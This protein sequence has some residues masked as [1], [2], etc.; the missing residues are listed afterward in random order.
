V[1]HVITSL[2]LGN[3]ITAKQIANDFSDDDTDLFGDIAD[4][5]HALQYYF[6]D[7]IIYP[8]IVNKYATWRVVKAESDKL[9]GYEPMAFHR[10][11]AIVEQAKSIS[12]KR[13]DLIILTDTRPA[14]WT[15]FSVTTYESAGLAVFLA[16]Y[17]ALTN[18]KAKRVAATG[19]IERTL[20]P[21]QI[22]GV[23]KVGAV[24]QKLGMLIREAGFLD[25]E[26]ILYPMANQGQV[27]KKIMRAARDKGIELLAV[28]DIADALDA[29]FPGHS[30]IHGISLNDKVRALEA[31]RFVTPYDPEYQD[32]VLKTGYALLD[33]LSKQ[34]K[35]GMEHVIVSTVTGHYHVHRGE[36]DQAQKVLKQGLVTARSLLSSNDPWVD[37]RRVI[38]LLNILAILYADLYRFEQAEALC[39][40][41]M[42][43]GVNE[44]EEYQHCKGTFGQVLTHYTATLYTL[45][46]S[47]E[48]SKRLE[49]AIMIH[50][51]LIDI[52][53]DEKDRAR[54]MTY[55]ANALTLAGRENDAEDIL[56]D[57]IGE[58][59]FNDHTGIAAADT[60]F[61][62]LALANL[63][64]ESQKFERWL[65]EYHQIL[66]PF[67]D[68][69]DKQN[70]DWPDMGLGLA[71]MT[72]YAATGRIRKAH[73]IFNILNKGVKSIKTPRRSLLI[74]W[75]LALNKAVYYSNES[76][77]SQ[78]WDNKA[79]DLL[80]NN[81]PTDSPLYPLIRDNRICQ[82]ML[83]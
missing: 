21:N 5:E 58:P 20:V 81:L 82:A 9:L 8:V 28:K 13:G 53:A 70:L 47:E 38:N 68:S 50:S 42:S 71:S 52:S 16:A 17:G 6:K 76:F 57:L 78:K 23:E 36:A 45:G 62:L 74:L 25:L 12:G 31:S 73:K 43:L 35:R 56:A 14:L 55:L 1:E 67:E 37:R 63:R 49:Q 83:F 75:G 40:E 61:S 51:R 59:L 24:P 18:R 72:A 65:N 60:C 46:R 33:Q 19:A 41:A 66:K 11:A 27:S 69:P 79:F 15:D 30:G 22:P 29:V 77:S 54:H 32:L 10:A 2:M 39:E 44:G 7:T 48:T 3:I 80:I 34:T 4:K 64:F 26:A